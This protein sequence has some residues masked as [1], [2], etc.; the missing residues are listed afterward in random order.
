MSTRISPHQMPDVSRSLDKD[1]ALTVSLDHPVGIVPDLFM[2]SAESSRNSDLVPPWLVTYGARNLSQKTGPCGLQGLQS[3]R[4]ADG[5][6]H[7][8]HKSPRNPQE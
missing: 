5:E 7:P 2:D 4:L 3:A 1:A 6:E 8:Y